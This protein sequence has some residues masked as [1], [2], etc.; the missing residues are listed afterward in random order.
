MDRESLCVLVSGDIDSAVALAEAARGPVPVLPVYVRSGLVWEPAEMYWLGRFLPSLEAPALEPLEIL[1]VPVR[2]LYGD[3]WSL[4]GEDPPGRESPDEAVYLPGRNL[5][6]LAKTGVL[7]SRRGCRAIVMGPL[8]ANPFPDGR[9]VFFDRMGEAIGLAMGLD[10]PLPVETPLA[11]LSKADVI[12][13][14]RHLRLDLTF[15][16]LAP[17]P[18]HRHC[19]RCNKCAERARGFG[20]ARVEDP[21]EYGP[22]DRKRGSACGSW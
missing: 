12:R 19:G 13:R 16:C 10:G 11:G 2:D 21:T 4:T 6:L 7:A 20:Q 5:L 15:S 9:R 8:V 18:D 1:E 3:H 22:A 17:G 14:G